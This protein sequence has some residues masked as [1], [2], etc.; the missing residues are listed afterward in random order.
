MTAISKEK[1]SLLTCGD[2]KE[3][4]SY[5]H[6]TGYFT[7]IRHRFKAM[8][9]K[10]AGC[11]NPLG[12]TAIYLKGKSYLAHRLAFL[13]MTGKYPD[14][15]VDHIN[16]SKS[17]NRF[18]NLRV[19]S[20]SENSQNIALQQ[21]N[22]H[23]LQGVT[24]RTDIADGNNWV[25]IIS[26][27]NKKINLGT[28]PT[29]EDAHAAYV[30]AKQKLH[31]SDSTIHEVQVEPPKRKNKHDLTGQTFNRLTVQKFAYIKDNLRFWEATCT[32]GNVVVVGGVYLKNG[33]TKSCGC[34]AKERR[35]QGKKEKQIASRSET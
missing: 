21:K 27:K 13:Y 30:M 23:G 22:K 3:I 34:Y 17:D 16:R 11:V 19:V 7:W 29:K 32:C 28:F 33:N 14:G 2:L 26:V 10:K 1:E 20:Q 4:L 12:Y 35:I 25:A 31:T 24:K 6:E 9:G 8:V 18:S 15:T 5:N